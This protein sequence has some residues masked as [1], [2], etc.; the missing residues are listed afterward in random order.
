[1]DRVSCKTPGALVKLG[2]RALPGVSVRALNYRHAFH[3]GNFGD[4]L[5]HT[6][7]LAV[8]RCVHH[9]PISKRGP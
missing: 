1:M 3:A 5:K 7:L 9:Q 6:V 4:C 8:L 2:T